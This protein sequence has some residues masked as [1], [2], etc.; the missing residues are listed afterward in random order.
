M[1]PEGPSS[2]CLRR[3]GLSARGGVT[4][5]PEQSVQSQS[6]SHEGGGSPLLPRRPGHMAQSAPRLPLYTLRRLRRR[7]TH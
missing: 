4:A 2:D 6:G 7:T 5:Q 1:F 3:P